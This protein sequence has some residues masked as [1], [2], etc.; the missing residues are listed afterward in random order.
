MKKITTSFCKIS[1]SILALFSAT[2]TLK[3]QTFEYKDSGTDFILY[4]M[5][6]P[7]GQN[8]VAFAAGAQNTQNSPGV[9]IR[10]QDGG[11]TWETVY[12]ITGESPGF[13]KIEFLT[14][15]KGFAVG[16]NIVLKT[17]D[18]G[19]S[20]EEITIAD[21]VNRYVSLN[22]FNE[23]VG[24]VTAF[25]TSG[26]GFEIYTTNDG[27]STWT[28]T[29]SIDNVGSISLDYA[30]ETTVFSVG[31]NER[32]AKSI[33]GGNTWET[34]RTGMPQFFSLEVFFKDTNNGIVASEDGKLEITHDGG[35]TWNQFA[36]GYHNFY[37]LYY[38]ADKLLAAGTDQD[39]YI[40]EDNGENWTQI[41]DG[42]GTSTFY[43]IQLFANNSGLVCGS[44]GT[45]LKFEDVLL[46]I[47]DQN[48]IT[49]TIT[50]FYTAT[51]KELTV[52]STKETIEQ[53]TLYSTSGQLVKSIN[54][55][56]NTAVIH[57]SDVPDGMYIASIKTLKGSKTIKFLKF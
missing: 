42:E 40:S 8:N 14:A 32:I 2:I 18:G 49:E 31:N 27:G 13:E 55:N 52:A 7:S 36:T 57:I 38:T 53:V 37:G 43:E 51:N 11:D 44:Q 21:N 12:P 15:D 29:D 34:V 19:D 41:H 45:M 54:N 26:V 24:I 56:S 6:I 39:L 9:I 5:S 25:V 33:D 35:E 46:G 1:F 47:E 48:T 10:S 3:A 23:N 4:D 28:I 22:F 17:E 20:W 16:Y 50:S 30:D